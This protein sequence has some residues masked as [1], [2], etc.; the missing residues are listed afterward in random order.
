MANGMEIASLFARVGADVGGFEKGMGKVKDDLTSAQ[1]GFGSFEKAVTVGFKAIGVAAATAFA[2]VGA[3]VVS[4]VKQAADFE[5]GVADIGAVM[6]LTDKEAQQLGGHI[7]DLGLDPTLKVSANEATDA[8][9]SLGTAGLSMDQIMEGADKAVIRLSNST[10][11][12]MGD[13]AALVTDIMGQYNL[14]VSDT[15]HIVDQVTGLTVASKFAFNDAALAYAQAGGVA[16]SFGLTMEDTNAILGVTSSRFS[17]GSDAGTSFKTFLTTLI[18]KSQEAEDVMSAL[19]L[20]TIDYT[21]MA[22]YLSG[23]LGEQVAPNIDSVYNAF[24]K[25][26]VGAAAAEK[27]NDA[28]AKAFNG[29]KAQYSENQFFDDTTG[30]MKDAAAIAGVLDAAFGDLSQE[31]KNEALSTIF[32]NDAM[33]TAIGLMDAGSEGVN[34]MA[35]EIAKVD[36]GSIAAERMDTF[37]GALEIAQGVVE[38]LSI[39]I[40]QNFLPILRPLIEQ[41]SNLA[42]T[43]GPRLVAFFGDLAARMGDAIQKGIEWAQAVLPP[44][45]QRMTEVGNAVKIVS[46]HVRLAIKP[47]TDAIGKWVG[48]QDILLAVGILL[49]GAVLTAIGG[50][51]AAMAPVILLVAKVTA[52]IVA[53]KAAWET[54]FLGIRD[55]TEDVLD[56]IAG[57]IQTYTNLWRGDWGKTLEYFRTNTDEVWRQLVHAVKS[58][59][60]DMVRETKHEVSVWIDYLMG[61]FDY[62]FVNTKMYLHVWVG[63]VQRYFREAK[64]WAIEQLEKLFGWFKPSEWLQKGRDIIEGLWDGAKQAWQGFKD[65]WSRLWSTLTGTVDVKMKIGSPSKE[66][67]K[68][69]EWAIEGFAIGAQNAMPL[70]MGAMGGLA[71]GA[72]GAASTQSA[73][74]TSRIEQLLEVL[75]A[76]LRAKNMNVTVNGGG[77]QSITAF[78]TIESGLR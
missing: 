7:M 69:G 59:I 10:G 3:G 21:R 39:S 51:I 30:N 11:G 23:V 9:M 58:W 13:S 14:T 38:T 75:I 20:V 33:R 44:L 50:F 71:G 12:A 6:G 62:Y 57:W 61:K 56:R 31:Q 24:K 73:V 60:H 76:E 4:A 18:P 74:S 72:L 67:M 17:S 49:G 64:E 28:L 45:W 5:Q 8:I 25:T 65:W 42:Q 1:K 40:G 46:D 52:V 35:A 32:G 63:W 66:M 19:G 77:G 55:I 68:R 2:A 47:I 70:A 41:F 22:E 78:N 43:Q 16:G 54:N 48:W 34:K 27:G 29:L 26:T 15:A 36:A 53:L 37:A